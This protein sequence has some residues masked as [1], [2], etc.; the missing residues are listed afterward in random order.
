MIVIGIDKIEHFRKFSLISFL[1][2]TILAFKFYL[3]LKYKIEILA[4][5]KFGN[6][7]FKNYWNLF[8]VLHV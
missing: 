8:W 7:K 5:T 4:D 3:Q 2:L 1:K 6:D